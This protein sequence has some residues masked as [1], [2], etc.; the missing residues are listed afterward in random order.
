MEAIKKLIGQYKLKQNYYDCIVPVTGAKDSFF[1][2]H[3]VKLV[4]MNPLLVYYNKYWNLQ[5]V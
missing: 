5:L 2:V 3:V 4:K 1:T